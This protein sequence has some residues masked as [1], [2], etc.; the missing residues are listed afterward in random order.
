MALYMLEGFETFGSVGTGGF[1][2]RNAMGR[3]YTVV[4]HAT[5][6]NNPELVAGW[7]SGCALQWN[8][9][10]YCSFSYNLPAVSKYI[11]CGFAYRIPAIRLWTNVSDRPIVSGLTYDGK[12]HFYLYLGNSGQIRV[13]VNSSSPVLI[14]ATSR[15]LKQ[16]EW[17][18][19]EF[20]TYT[21]ASSGTFDIRINGENVLTYSGDTRDGSSPYTS[22]IVFQDTEDCAID[23]IYIMGNSDD[24]DTYLGPVKVERLAPT[25]DGA[26]SDWTPSANA[27]HYTLV[28]EIP[29][30]SSDYIEA[31]T[32]GDE[33]LFE[34]AN[35][36]LAS[37]AAVKITS[38]LAANGGYNEVKHRY[39]SGSA[40]SYDGATF[41]VVDTTVAEKSE[42]L[43][44]DPDTNAAWT[45]TNLNSAQFGAEIV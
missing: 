28:D 29:V 27:D 22:R 23:D 11:I 5:E 14:G 45:T 30:N 33:E 7:G 36:S 21:D 19:I 15:G 2:L 37:I 26:V 8:M 3:R 20:K 25:A 43:V 6:G 40:N 10:E 24:S 44:V 18:Y 16:G 38:D 39:R 34:Y 12:R 9:S 13:Y 42:I 17:A 1:T 35:T 4:S 31:S 41:G 32:L